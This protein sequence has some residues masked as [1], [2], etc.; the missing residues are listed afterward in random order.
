MIKN[1]NQLRRAEERLSSINR[2]I[3]EYQQ[4]IPGIEKELFIL[5]LVDEEQKIK[6]EISEYKSLRDLPFKDA[7]NLILQQP[8]LIENISELLAK[9]RIAAKLTQEEMAQL[10]QWEQANVSRFENENYSSQTIGKIV[11]FVNSLGI[12]LHVYPSLTE[13]TT[14]ITIKKEVVSTTPSDELSTKNSWNWEDEP[15]RLSTSS[16]RPMPRIAKLL[17]EDQV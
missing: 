2:E 16:H 3:E 14:K 12:W 13:Q 8:V 4:T 7:V 17:V 11:E 9:L 10:L 5:P 15:D 6:D 1:D